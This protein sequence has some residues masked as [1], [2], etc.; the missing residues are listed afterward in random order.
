MNETIRG[1]IATTI[2]RLANA[3]Y[4]ETIMETYQAAYNGLVRFCEAEGVKAYTTEVGENFWMYFRKENPN[5]SR[6][7]VSAYRK[8][9]KHLNCAFLG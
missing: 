2:N 7:R 3:G 9:I 4:S 6:D 1:L 5:M 8:G